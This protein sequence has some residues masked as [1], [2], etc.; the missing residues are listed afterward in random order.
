MYAAA[1]GQGLGTKARGQFRKEEEEKNA[2]IEQHSNALIIIRI[3]SNEFILVSHNTNLSLVFR[4]IT[5]YN[6]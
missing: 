3:L 2:L 1:I 6:N 5:R 4:I